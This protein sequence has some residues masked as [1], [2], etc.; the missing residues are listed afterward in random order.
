MKTKFTLTSN[1]AFYTFL[2]LT[3]I[4]SLLLSAL[5]VGLRA[6]VIV[7]DLVKETNETQAQLAVNNLTQYLE[8]RKQILSNLLYILLS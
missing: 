4:V 2:G 3:A 6:N 7:E 1:R 8:S 5:F